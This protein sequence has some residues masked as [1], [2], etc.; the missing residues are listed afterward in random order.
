M[1]PSV[2]TRSSKTG[3]RLRFEQEFELPQRDDLNTLD[4]LQFQNLFV[5]SD[6]VVNPGGE[7]GLHD[8]NIVGITGHMTRH[9]IRS[10]HQP[11][12]T[13]HGSSRENANR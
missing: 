5:R 10:G 2:V 7:C 11:S 1:Q 9:G 6:Q 3:S 13:Q 8:R 4:L 12:D